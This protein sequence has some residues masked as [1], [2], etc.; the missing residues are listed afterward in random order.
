M[1]ALFWW[2]EAL[3]ALYR[4]LG[5]GTPF[6]APDVAPKERAASAAEVSLVNYLICLVKV[7]GA[8]G[9]EPTTR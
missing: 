5:L 7:V 4:V 2:S 6:V 3:S 8:V 9:L 1:D